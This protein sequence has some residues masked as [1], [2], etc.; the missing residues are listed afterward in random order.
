M[1]EGVNDSRGTMGTFTSQS[2]WFESKKSK[3]ILCWEMKKL[4]LMCTDFSPPKSKMYYKF[5]RMKLYFAQLLGHM[6]G[7]FIHV[8]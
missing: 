8:K 5:G 2:H 6:V 7:Q 4:I 3:E 1:K